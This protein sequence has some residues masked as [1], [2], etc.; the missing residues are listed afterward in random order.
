MPVKTEW[1]TDT[2]GHTYQGR[3]LY[4][5][6]TPFQSMEIFE[7]GTFG[8]LLFLDGKIQISR[9][10]ENRYHQYLVSAPLLAHRD[11]KSICVIGGG[12]CFALEEAVK[13]RSLKRILMVE[14]DKGV[15]DFCRK[16]YPEIEKV[17]KDGRV[18][19]VYEDARKRLETTSETFD[20]L[21][22]DL[23]E[24]HGP[25]KM[26]Y[27]REF[28]RTCQKKLNPG[29]II[30][31]HTDNYYLFPESFATIYKTFHSV[32]PNILTARVDMPCFGMGWT[33]R[34]ASAKPIS[35]KMMEKNI[36]KMKRQGTTFDHFTPSLYLVKPTNEELK[37]LKTRG[38]VSTDRR[39]FDKFEKMQGYVT[40]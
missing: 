26:L 40:K 36:Q 19:L 30:A 13:F 3:S 12:D 17:L 9:G 22:I 27:T 14:I 33:Y 38:R 31:I 15:V 4:R 20:V 25:S 1:T 8:T 32:F 2:F 10:D 16:H 5:G 6:R 23:T 39:P 11:P 24:P 29:G 37:V 21:I 18:D 28:Y 34:M 35:L 7:N